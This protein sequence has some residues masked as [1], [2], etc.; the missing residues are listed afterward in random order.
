MAER[1]HASVWTVTGSR[2]LRQG[3]RTLLSSIPGI[4]VTGEATDAAAILKTDDD[5][6][7]DLILLD[8]GL[9]GGEAWKALKN[10]KDRWPQVH[11]FV[12]ADDGYQAQRARVFADVVLQ[13]GMPAS[14]LVEMIEMVLG[15]E[16]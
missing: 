4:E 5:C 11:C 6:Q 13:K 12:L 3:L 16:A 7:P 10:I 9:P 1:T 2:P 15:R 14:A 8:A